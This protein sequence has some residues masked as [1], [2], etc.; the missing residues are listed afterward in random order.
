MHSLKDRL[1][2]FLPFRDDAIVFL[3]HEMARCH[4]K[5]STFDMCVR[6]EAF[7]RHCNKFYIY[8]RLQLGEHA[9][10]ISK[11]LKKW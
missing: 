6:I 1:L 8:A 2:S 4:A 7:N 3:G 10:K 5:Y 9:L 11:D